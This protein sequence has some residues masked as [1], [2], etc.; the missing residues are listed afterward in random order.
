MFSFVVTRLKTVGKVSKILLLN[1]SETTS[2]VISRDRLSLSNSVTTIK[3][4]VTT[5]TI[6]L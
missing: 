4:E 2:V 5:D 6:K 3:I 1:T